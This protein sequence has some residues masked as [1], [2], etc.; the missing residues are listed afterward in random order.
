MSANPA[1]GTAVILRVRTPELI[2]DG[3]PPESLVDIAKAA[4]AN[5]D[6]NF[7]I[8]DDSPTHLLP[9]A[10][11]LNAFDPEVIDALADSLS[12]AAEDADVVLLDLMLDHRLVRF[13]AIEQLVFSAAEK[14][15]ASWPLGASLVVLMNRVPDEDDDIAQIRHLI[16]F[17]DVVL[18]LDE[19]GRRLGSIWDD[20]GRLERVTEAAVATPA[21]LIST[22]RRRALRRRGVFRV[23]TS[24]RE[25]Y[26]AYRYSVGD[27]ELAAVLR[28]YFA[29]NRIDVAI[30]ESDIEVWL[31][32]AVQGAASADTAVFPVSD[33]AAD[34]DRSAEFNTALWEKLNDPD[35]RVCLVIPMLK[36]GERATALLKSLGRDNVDVL[37]IFHGSVRRA[38]VTATPGDWA[39]E[40]HSEALD[41][42]VRFIFDVKLKRLFPSH[43]Q[44][45]MARLFHE[46]TLDVAGRKWQPSRTGIWALLNAHRQ[47]A[48]YRRRDHGVLM[49]MHLDD[50]DAGW[51]AAS[52]MQ[53]MRETL[54][55]DE[56]EVLLVLPDDQDTA[57]AAI[58]DA[59]KTEQM[60]TVLRVPRKVIKSGGRDISNA[61][62]R[63]LRRFSNGSIVLVDESTA[64][65]ATLAGL[66]KVVERVISRAADLAV[67]VLDLPEGGAQPPE[68]FPLVRIYGWRPSERRIYR[69]P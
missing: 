28:G 38:E 40:A 5:A 35:T 32:V 8:D 44:V 50:W 25:H 3:P 20:G 27:S 61:I 39:R 43:W 19:R 7:V 42:P 13:G 56:D 67:V 15:E 2:A 55:K 29:A 4:M 69:Q 54:G 18:F 52:I 57:I 14:L 1:S 41:R 30:F 59:L 17:K 53:L 49:R 62:A 36:N 65:Y 33:L 23:A 58:A 64:T 51:L 16:G 68:E 21:E 45:Q 26:A 11:D 66:N 60:T 22:A 48:E 63:E 24:P 46:D 10:F 34:G 6:Y 37:T 9:A 12:F 47:Q 31:G